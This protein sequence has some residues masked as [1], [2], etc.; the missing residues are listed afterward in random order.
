MAH[1]VFIPRF[2]PWVKIKVYWPCCM[3]W[4]CTNKVLRLFAHEPYD[5]KYAHELVEEFPRFFTK[6]D[7]Y[8]E[9]KKEKVMLDI[10]MEK[11]SISFE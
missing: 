7:F 9:E 2:T 10:D 4:I 11:Y 8:T 6:I 1:L 3:E 5:V